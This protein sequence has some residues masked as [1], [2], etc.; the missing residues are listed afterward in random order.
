M[1]T[2]ELDAYYERLG[3]WNRLAG[4]FGYGGGYASLTVHRALADPRAGGRATHTRLHDIIGSHLPA[5]RAPRVL[6]AGFGLCGTM[7]DL[8]AAPDATCVG[9]TLSRAK[10]DQA[11]E[12]AAPC[13]LAGRVHALVRR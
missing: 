11:N 5:M 2:G 10:C 3:T 12:A 7:L 9:L 1:S 13:G 8:A 4:L 6:D